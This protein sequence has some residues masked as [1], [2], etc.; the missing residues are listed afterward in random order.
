MHEATT[1]V[2]GATG[3]IG[4]WLVLDLISQGHTITA[5]MRNP[6]TQLPRLKEWISQRGGD[7]QKLTAIQGDLSQENLGLSANDF[8]KLT[9][10]EYIF[11]LGAVMKWNLPIAEAREVNVRPVTLLTKLAERSPNFKRFVQMTGFMI[12]NE[13]RKTELGLSQAESV[14]D[15][16]WLSLY[17][18][19]GS[20]EASKYES[21]FKLVSLLKQ[22]SIPYTVINPGAVIGHSATGEITQYDSIVAMIHELYKGTLPAIPGTP[23]DWLPVIPVDF[24]ARFTARVIN[25]PQSENQHYTL[26]DDRTPD[27]AT[28]LGFLSHS[29]FIP[30]VKRRV[31]ILLL[32][33]IAKLGLESVL[34]LPSEPLSFISS[35]RYNIDNTKSMASQLG[36]D[37]PPFEEYFQNFADYLLMT[38][39]LQSDATPAAR[40]LHTGTGKVYVVGNVEDPQYVLLHGLPL[41]SDS[42]KAIENHY[43]DKTLRIDLPGLGRSTYNQADFVSWLADLISTMKAPPILMG[44]SLGTGL[45][46]ELAHRFPEKIAGLVLISPYFLGKKPAKWMTNQ[47]AFR[48][49]TKVIPKLRLRKFIDGIGPGVK[50]AKAQLLLDT[51]SRYFLPAIAY[52]LNNAWKNAFLLRSCYS[53]TNVPSLLIAGEHDQPV[54]SEDYPVIVIKGAGHNP[55]LTHPRKVV[56][57]LE[58]HEMT[59]CKRCMDSSSP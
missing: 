43:P 52:W 26:I 30:V 20:Y 4:K 53:E 21:H 16:H 10:L 41:N 39:F 11:H 19:L 24:V 38:R 22:K 12:E 28:M 18:R 40:L 33:T 34:P 2:T 35:D 57:E 51:D 56:H 48:T 3:F 55:Q 14:S 7:D 45:A 42:W 27:L 58:N 1:L 5:L 50:N 15:K 44:H 54:F 17:K 37:L 9:H 6:D 29:F 23:K 8:R 13:K 47:V 36:L 46:V 32:K 59:H 25:A 49:I 31:P